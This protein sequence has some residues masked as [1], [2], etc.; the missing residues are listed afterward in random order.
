V[1][2]LVVGAGVIGL[3]TAVTLAEAGYDVLVRT[4]EEPNATTSAAAGALWGPWLVEPVHRTIPWAECGLQ[5]LSALATRPGTGVRLISGRDV[6]TTEHEPPSWFSLLPDTRPCAANELPA[7][8]AHGT[9]YTA[10]LVD[11]PTHL[12]YLVERLRAAG[13]VIVRSPVVTLDEATGLAPIVVNC[14]GLGARAFADDQQLYPVRGQHLVATNPGITEFLE[15]DTGDSTDLV[16]IY[17]HGDHVVLGGTAEPH[18]WS[19]EPNP[20]TAAAI[21]ARCVA[22]EPLLRDADVLGHR[23]G[24]RPTR[25]E[26][27]LDSE[28]HPS[29]ARVIHNY[30]HGGAGVSLAW[31]CAAE[32]LRSIT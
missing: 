24:L 3:T 29:G 11:M 16:A 1:D 8:Y 7:G 23:I 31:G 18:L 15:V 9:W 2:V 26:V 22:V 19:R 27:R 32:V 10:P 17:P 28:T 5:T 12:A 14:T 25:P 20:A 6:S 21:L 30:G 13:G 4:A